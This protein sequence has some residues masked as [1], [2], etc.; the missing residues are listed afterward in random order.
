M[1]KVHIIT[2]GEEVLHGEL[3]D[4]NAAWLSA[5]VTQLGAHPVARFT[6]GDQ[7]SALVERFRVSANQAEIVLVNGGLGPTSDDLTAE[8][9]ARAFDLPLVHRTEWEVK[10]RE[11]FASRGRE[12]PESNLKQCLLPEACDLL[13]NPIG[14]AC[15]FALNHGN[16]RFYFSPGVPREMERMFSE[17]I[18]PDLVQR[19]G[20]ANNRVM[21]RL[22]TFGVSEARMGERLTAVNTD[23][24][25][26]LGYRAHFPTLEIKIWSDAPD[27]Q[28]RVETFLQ[29]VPDDLMQN[30]IFRDQEQLNQWLLN[31]L[32]ARKFRLACAESCSGG[33]LFGDFVAVPGSSTVMEEGF[34]T[35]SNA[36]KTRTLGVSEE[37]LERHGAVSLQVA[38]DMARGA[39][40]VSGAS[41]ALSITGIAGPDGGTPEKPVGTIAFGLATPAGDYAQ[42]LE[43]INLGRHKLRAASVVI[44]QDMLRR[45]L[46]GQSV[47]GAFDL[48]KRRGL[49]EP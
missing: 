8:A 13:D 3:V 25:V 34:V 22:H 33:L 5:Q 24:L 4:T 1:I 42:M 17:Q 15:G 10:M 38:L 9:A 12:M 39:V 21:R 18:A 19:F 29:R 37:T 11:K 45:H 43:I 27:A 47:F 20:L 26:E 16:T 14:T 28:S 6:V 23:H 40:Q 32:Q 41:H 49:V 2:T 35:Y 44:A 7:L 46:L 48:A 30:V 31:Q 36:A